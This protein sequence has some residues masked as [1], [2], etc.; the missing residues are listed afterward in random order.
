MRSKPDFDE[1]SEQAAVGGAVDAE[2]VGGG[3]DVA[4]EDGGAA[5]VER[6]GER[7]IGMDPLQAVVGEGVVTGRELPERR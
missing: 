2:S 3:V 6:M 7:H 5:A 4:V 1:R